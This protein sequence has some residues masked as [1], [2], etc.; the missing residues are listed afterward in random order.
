[1][2]DVGKR[3]QVAGMADGTETGASSFEP[4]AQGGEGRYRND[5][6]F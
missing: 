5:V 3:W 4:E 6:N 2:H 1:M